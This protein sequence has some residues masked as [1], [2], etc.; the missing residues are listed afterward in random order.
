M[1][2]L[3]LMKHT[4]NTVY[5]HKGSLRFSRMYLIKKIFKSTSTTGNS[6]NL[7]ETRIDEKTKVANLILNRS[8]VN[9]LSLEMNIAIS[10]A[11]KSIDKR[12][13]DV[14]SV[15]ISSSSPNILSAGLDL[16]EMYR[17]DL[18]RLPRYWNSVQ[19][20]FLDLYGSRLA[21]ICAIE[22]HAPGAG[23]LLAMA[24][25]YRIMAASDHD[26]KFPPS[27]GL[28]ETRFGFVAPPFLAKL[29]F[30]TIGIRCGEKAL[31]LGTLFRAEEALSIGLVDEL[32]PAHYVVQRS[33][34]VAQEWNEIN[35]KARFQS[36]MIGRK[37][38]IDDLL[39]S[40]E[41]DTQ[42]FCNF[43]TDKHVQSSLTLYMSS[44]KNK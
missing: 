34:E 16:K 25:D 43:V 40:R 23:C 3:Y 6:T 35:P 32:V 38:F 42:H 26:N 27:I 1:T 39:T 22:G 13:S 29:L 14:Q 31:Q 19:Q 30:R 12:Y 37:E 20:L 24:C 36:K 44:L 8:P 18:Q 7:V 11:L 4:I 10:D 2:N 15:I 41:E 17:P 33:L 9:S 21:T 28:N 5:T